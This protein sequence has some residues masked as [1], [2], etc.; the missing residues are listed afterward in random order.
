[1]SS[2][3]NFV[4]R[5]MR[6]KGR[7]DT[8]RTADDT[9]ASPATEMPVAGAAAVAQSE[10]AAAADASFDPASLPP[11]EAIGIDTDISAFLQSGVPAALTRAALRQAWSSDPAIRDF[12]GIAENQWDFN[13]PNAISGFGPLPEGYDVRALLSQ[14]LGRRDEPAEVIPQMRV[15]VEQLRVAATDHEAAVPDQDVHRDLRGSQPTSNPQGLPGGEGG[16]NAVS[17]NDHVTTADDSPRNHR[18]HGGALPQ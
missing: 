7:S 9:P 13:D 6:L 16:E 2:P 15:P 10:F 18:S 5:W 17:G 3:E 8:R 4:S 1:M 14:A 12:I 11:I